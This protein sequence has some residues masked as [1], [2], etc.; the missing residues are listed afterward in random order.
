MALASAID[1]FALHGVSKQLSSDIKGGSTGSSARACT[2]WP[3]PTSATASLKNVKPVIPSQTIFEGLYEKDSNAHLPSAAA[4]AVHLEFLAALR[5]IR[6]CVLESEDLD[7]VFDTKLTK[8]KVTRKG[9]EVELKDDT[10]KERRQV[11]WEKYVELAVVRFLAWLKTVPDIVTGGKDNPVLLE[12]ALP[13]L[14][15]SQSLFVSVLC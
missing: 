13:P 11:K 15:G 9:V 2:L 4:C 1:I 6:D 12:T 7:E 14:G 10:L 5:S 8:K 3:I